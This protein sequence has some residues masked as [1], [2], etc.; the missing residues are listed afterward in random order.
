MNACRGP[1]G[2]TR[3]AL[4]QLE[5][6]AARPDVD[7]RVISGR[8]HEPDGLLY[9][10]S[11]GN[12]RRKELPVGLRHALR[13]WR[14]CSRPPIEWWS[15]AV[16]WVYCPAEYAVP[17]RTAKLAVTSHDVLQDLQYGGQRRRE[18]LART[19]AGANLILSVSRFNTQQ[20]I[21]AFPEA[22]GRVAYVPNGAEDL[23]F[24]TATNSE[25]A[26]VRSD[27]GLPKGMPY[28]L[29]VANFQP[30][31]NLG[32]L[33]SAVGRLPEV[34]RGELALV[35]L[36]DGSDEQARPIREAITAL[37][38]KAIVR[39]PGYRQG[40]ALRA[41]YAEAEALVFPST[42]ESFGI[43]AVEAMAQ[44]C[45]VALANNTALPEVGGDAAWYFDPE[46]EESIAESLR[47]LLGNADVRAENAQRG[48]EIAAGF[49]WAAANE[50]LVAAFRGEGLV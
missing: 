16:D 33:V 5:R 38:R 43:P 19:F 45:A 31:K 50:R 32:R 44:G 37:G 39:I 8:I 36:G 10:E 20:L 7:L 30:R 41:V 48:R 21:A 13:Y 11:L 1:T 27:L 6:L 2:V 34:S 47:S 9:W 14:L 15:G 17:T 28:L 25:R 40:K 24:E 46:S 12:V 18:R 35:L 3:H 4:A 23:Y 22:A 49:R 42:C 29:S 26:L